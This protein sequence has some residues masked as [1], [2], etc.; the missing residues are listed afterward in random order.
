M[1]ADDIRREV[2]ETLAAL[3]FTDRQYTWQGCEVLFVM[4]DGFERLRFPAGMSGREVAFLLGKLTGRVE[5]IAEMTNVNTVA[6]SQDNTLAADL[7][8]RLVR[9]NTRMW[10]REALRKD[11]ETPA[12]AP[13]SHSLNGGGSHGG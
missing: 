2:N 12:V 13:V 10:E 7:M 1:R 11:L 4:N 8:E 9:P 3:G 6:V 5:A